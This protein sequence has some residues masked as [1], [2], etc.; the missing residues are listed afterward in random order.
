MGYFEGLL[1]DSS[2]SKNTRDDV[3]KVVNVGQRRNGQNEFHQL[4]DDPNG[5]CRV[6]LA[7]REEEKPPRRKAPP[8]L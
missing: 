5:D 4:T 1:K 3:V 6:R 2:W 7:G 8:P